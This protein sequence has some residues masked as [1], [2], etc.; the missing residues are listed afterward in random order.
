YPFQTGDFPF[1]DAD[2]N[3]LLNVIITGVTGV[4]TLSY[5]GTP[6]TDL[7]AVIAAADIPGGLFTFTPP[8]NTFADNLAGFTFQ[9]QDKGGTAFAGK[10]TS[11]SA[12]MTLNAKPVNTPPSFTI[13]GADPDHITDED[14]TTHGP[15][16][17]QPFP[18]FVGNI[19]PGSTTFDIGQSL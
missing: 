14:P 12:S 19:K 17:V 1:N 6:I 7:P 3:G 5:K 8:A 10:D 11:T 15:A 4:G 16:P 18:N 13:V 2:N 9:V